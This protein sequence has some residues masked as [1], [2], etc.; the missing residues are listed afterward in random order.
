MTPPSS[1]APDSRMMAL[2]L[3]LRQGGVRDEKVINSMERVPR[4]MFVPPAFADRAFENCALPI[5][6]EQTVSQPLVVAQM[7]EA[8]EL[9]DRHKVLEIGTGSG[10]QASV[11]APLCRRLYT[12]ERHR[13][14]KDEAEARF[15]QLGI[16]N[17]TTMCGDGSAGWPEQAP[18][19]RIIVTAAA[20]DVP[21]VLVDQLAEGG[22]MVVPVGDDQHDQRLVKLTRG[23]DGIETEEM[24]WVRF[25]PFVQ[26]EA[27][28]H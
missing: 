2:V 19:D 21:P 17:I 6:F 10:Y 8:L 27:P 14:L 22:I 5:G 26:G 12:I 20:H 11:L 16:H 4:D 9:T 24:G 3:A 28:G 13:G 1:S 25:V 7:T 15:Q 18:F 23:P